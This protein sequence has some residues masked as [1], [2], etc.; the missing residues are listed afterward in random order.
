MNKKLMI[1]GILGLFAL[2]LV[3]AG[4]MSYFGVI[5]KTVTVDQGL[6]VDGN[7][8]DA[9]IVEPAVTM[10]SF[11]N[12]VFASAHRLSNVANVDVGVNLVYGCSA[13]DSSGGCNDINTNYYETNLRSGSLTLSKKDPSWNEITTDTDVVVTYSTNA[14]GELV[15]DSI[16]GMDSGYILIY[17]ADEE[18]DSDGVR[19]ATPGQA[20]ALSIG[21][22]VP[23]SADD[24]NLKVGA[25][26]CIYDLYDHCRGIKLWLIRT[27][28]L[29][30]NTITWNE[31]WQ[32]EYYFETD[33]LGWNHNYELTNTVDVLAN[34]DVDFVI[35]SDFPELMKPDEYTL[36]TTVNLV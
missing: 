28:D 18:F 33:M 15:I 9:P 21:D 31:N 22:V 14:N 19:L 27:D 4:L 6:T 20:Y 17:Y 8:W 13:E 7:N 32:S 3:S 10:N 36:T 11:Q 5:N 24:G 26:Y 16:V 29:T 34:S 12:L 25:D 35:V 30:D 2:A 23:I 1:F